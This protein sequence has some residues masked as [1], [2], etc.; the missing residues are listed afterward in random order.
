[1]VQYVKNK[2]NPG[3][4][5]ETKNYEII[6]V[7]G[8]QD[9]VGCYFVEYESNWTQL[10]RL[11]LASLE[12]EDTFK[13]ISLFLNR[14]LQRY[15]SPGINVRVEIFNQTFFPMKLTKSL[16][17]SFTDPS[18]TTLVFLIRRKQVLRSLKHISIQNVTEQINPPSD[19][20]CLEIP[21]SLKKD[22]VDEAQSI[23]YRAKPEEDFQKKENKTNFSWRLE[24]RA[25]HLLKELR[26]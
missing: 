16:H 7:A 2:T 12:S 22:L 18:K 11:I 14:E 8:H 13:E 15:M 10:M 1:M 4:R 21:M 5:Q 9:N 20:Q 23:W 25:E 3:T 24:W 6:F 17:L 19:L 26:I